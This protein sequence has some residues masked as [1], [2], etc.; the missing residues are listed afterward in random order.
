MGGGI[1]YAALKTRASAITLGSKVFIR[2]EFFD[3]DGQVPLDLVAHEVAHVVQFA[4]DGLLRFFYYYLRDYMG[5]LFRGLGD[6]AAYRAIPYEVEARRVA[7]ALNTN[8]APTS[9]IKSHKARL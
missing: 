5:G 4:R 7:A 1:A 8:P 2:R 6:S 3:D 9:K